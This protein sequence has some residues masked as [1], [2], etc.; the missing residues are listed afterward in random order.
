[1]SAPLGSG[2]ATGTR[3]TEDMTQR[4]LAGTTTPAGGGG[5]LTGTAPGILLNSPELAW[6]YLQQVM[7]ADPTIRGAFSDYNQRVMGPAAQAYLNAILGPGGQGMSAIGPGFADLARMFQSG[8]LYGGLSGAADKAL[9][10]G[11]L[12]NTLN[13]AG[14]QTA[15]PWLQRMFALKSMNAGPLM[16]PSL[17]NQLEDMLGGY[18]DEAL[19][20]GGVN[21]TKFGKY[22][23]DSPWFQ[24]LGLGPR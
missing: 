21:T 4:A 20:H 17:Q 19:A 12:E 2:A 9:G 13:T 14:W 6:R 3:A 5:G 15:M 22:T 1:M 7:G 16:G 8:D 10:A 23:V 18:T 24:S 11:G